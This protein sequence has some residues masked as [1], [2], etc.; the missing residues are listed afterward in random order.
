MIIVVVP[1]KGLVIGQL[2]RSER[3]RERADNNGRRRC[4]E[5]SFTLSFLR[6]E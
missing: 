1:T 6:F 3:R 5:S 4:W 2:S